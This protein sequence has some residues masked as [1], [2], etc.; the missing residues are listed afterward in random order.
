[1]DL[2][3]TNRMISLPGYQIKEKLFESYNSYVFRAFQE[4]LELPV[5]I[6][7]L[8]GE[9]PDPE[10]IVR[11]K[12][13]FEILKG[14]T[15]E[16]TIKAYS[17]EN[18]NNSCAIVMEDFGAESLKKILE[19]RRLTLYEFLELSISISEILGQ[20]AQLNIIHKNVNP[21]NIVWNQETDQLKIIDFGISTVLSREIAAIQNPKEFEGT[22]SYI[23]PEQTGRMNRMI[24]Y[25]TDMYSLGVTLYEIITGHLPFPARDAMELVHCHLAKVPVPPH[26]L[27]S[28]ILTEE[29]GVPEILSKIIMK[30]MSKT[31]EDRYLSYYGLKYD[32]E[33]CLKYLKKTQTLSGLDFSPGENDFSDK[34]RIPQ[35][36]YGREAEIATLLDAFR[37]VCNRHQGGLVS[38]MMMVTGYAGIGKSAL[39]NEIHIPIVE[40]RGYFISGKSDRFKHNIPY[41]ALTQAFQDLMRQILMESESQ[42]NQWKSKILEAVGPNGQVIIDVIPEVE[43]IIGKQPPVPELPPRETQNRFNMYFQN[44]IRTFADESH[45]LAIF[46]DDLQW[47]DIPT[48]KLFERLMLDSKTRYLLIIGAYRD[49]EV[50]SS[51]PLVISLD[52]LKNENAVVNFITL[53][54]L[55]ARN[56]NQLISDSLKCSITDA[57]NLGKL[58]LEKTNGNPFFLIQFLNSLADQNLLEFDTDT[59]KWEWD[60]DLIEKA[61]ITSN[62]VD[63]MTARIEKLSERTKRILKLASC[64]GNR[65]DLDTLAIINEKPD[66]E[67]ANE[68]N[69]ALESGLIQPIGEGYRLAGYLDYLQDKNSS[70]RLGHE[71]QYK[72]LHDRVHQAA[73]TLMG[74]EYKGVHL[75][76][77]R[78]LIQKLSEEAREERIFDIVNHLN[79][80]IELIVGQTEKNQLAEMNLQAGRK[81]K[82]STAYEIAFQYFNIGLLLLGDNAWNDNYALTLEM[83]LETAEA[84]HLTGNFKK[85]DKLAGEITNHAKN[86]L[87]KIRISEIIIQSFMS[88]D[89][90]RDSIGIAV[91]ILRQLGVHISPEP[92]KISVL[93]NIFYLRIILFSKKIKDLKNLP[94]MTDSH[95]LAAM[96]IL[97]NAASSAYYTNILLSI[98]IAFKMIHL[99]VRY[100]NSPYSSFAYGLYGIILQS[101]VG[102]IILGYEFGKFSIDIL[103]KFNVKEYQARINFIFNVFIRHWKD[104]LSDTIEP[105]KESFQRGLETGDYEFGCLCSAYAGIHSFHSGIKLE[106]SEDEMKKSIEVATKLKQEVIL[107]GLNCN[108]QVALNF[109]GKSKSRALV[110]GESYNEKEMTPYLIEKNNR[111]DLGSLCSLKALL[112]IFFDDSKDSI[113]VALESEKYKETS[114]G[115]VYRVF[116]YFYTSLI[117]LSHLPTTPFRKRFLYKYRVFFNQKQLKK[118]ARYAP[119]NLMHKWHLVEAERCKTRGNQLRVIEHYDKAVSLARQNGYIHEEALANELAAKFYLAGGFER[120]ARVYMKEACYLYTIWGAMGKVDHLNETY[121][122]LLYVLPEL[123]GRGDGIDFA[124]SDLAGTYPEKLDLATVQKASQTISGEIHLDKLLEKLMNIVITNAGAQKGFFLLKDEEGLF[125]EGEAVA[126]KEE[127]IVLQHVPYTERE[128]IARVIINYVLRVN[129][130]IVLDDASDQGSFKA[131]EYVRSNKIRSVLCLPLIFKNKLSGILYLENNL[132]PGTFTSERVE[133]LKILTGQIVISIEN[134]RLYRSL[135]EYNRTLEEKV[136][137]RTAEISQKNEQLNIQKEELRTTLENLKHSQFQLLQSEKMASLGQLVAGIAHEINNPV[138]F[139]SAG[140]ESLNANLEEISQVLDIYNKITTLNVEAK[141]KEIEELKKKIEYKEAIREIDKLIVSIKN[142]TKRTT[143][144]VKGLRTFSR[145]DEDIIKTADLHEGLD[146]TLILLH[147][148]YKGRIEIIRNYGTIPQIESYP[149]QLNQV[150]MNILANAI[151]SIDSTGKITI[152]TTNIDGMVRISIIDTG[153]GIPEN[154]KER[155]FEPFY[156]TK[157]VGMGTGLGLSISHSIIEKH[158]GSI[159]VKSEVGK[160]SEFIIVLPVMQGKE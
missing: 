86:L 105:F 67:T 109:M 140:V 1:L 42:I 127:I 146:S 25:R 96:R 39:V 38:E 130:M 106:I 154:L 78:L 74:D 61:D 122:D 26:M 22:L 155:L 82:A 72:F 54:P 27:K 65:F 132:A 91:E 31:A 47:A 53:L 55:E 104:K 147:N 45:P 62:V 88:R 148:R 101:I 18:F 32:L 11:F 57:E 66:V 12:R 40:K 115:L 94:E 107:I 159:D 79:S 144:I 85:T 124:L 46:L 114:I 111:A 75:K 123:S 37:R 100:G 103:N 128:N 29:S 8:K 52:K 28:S 134:A 30:L 77:G 126:G 110:T 34:F 83:N 49:N 98:T 23:S 158:K 89:R 149:G 142:G 13:E 4:D 133:V 84:S 48:L 156:T 3:E 43:R 118:W 117:Y 121:S 69:E 81:A 113:R 87:D 125:V 138:N 14:L 63:L 41:W 102:K 145:M 97:M 6:K 93:L 35:K 160:G 136:E 76:I 120:I 59:L 112:C 139:I 116:I 17:L 131:D 10:R 70:E 21:T 44:F 152:T 80:G 108:R 137:R 9:Y 51:H 15:L 60:A 143:E 24:D 141:L 36:L 92:S 33:K 20:L 135:E 151:D 7:V 95:K 68:M 16:G 129:K 56:V 90:L 150:F 50:D 19:K 71:I 64:I 119:E 58:C 157:E 5:I 99:S 153:R 2:N 73:N